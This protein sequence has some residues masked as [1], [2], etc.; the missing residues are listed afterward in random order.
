MDAAE[1]GR[2]I[3]DLIEAW[4][5]WHVA[6]DLRE[7][8]H[9]AELVGSEG[10]TVMGGGQTGSDG[11]WEI[12]DGE[13]GEVVAT[14]TGFDSFNEA[15]QSDW[16]HEDRIGDRAF[17]RTPRPEGDYGLPPALASALRDWALD[18]RDEAESLRPT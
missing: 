6:V 15:W 12:V 7:N 4:L 11:E 8:T 2:A 5:R 10:L 16:V 9:A 3:Q 1:L 17:D 13:S 14:G 18:Q